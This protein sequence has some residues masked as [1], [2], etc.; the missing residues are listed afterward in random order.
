M[1]VMKRLVVVAAVIAAVA[2]G[3]VPGGPS[4]RRG[5]GV[6]VD[7]W[8]GEHS[9]LPG[10]RECASALSGGGGDHRLR[11]NR[12]RPRPRW[13]RRRWGS[14]ACGSRRASPSWCRS[15]SMADA[16]H[17]DA[18][19]G[20]DAHGDQSQGAGGDRG[21]LSRRPARNHPGRDRRGPGA[22]RAGREHRGRAAPGPAP[23]WWSRTTR[24]SD[25]ATA[26]S[27]ATSS[28]SSASISTTP[29]GSSRSRRSKPAGLGLLETSTGA[30]V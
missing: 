22:G 17:A 9:L 10:D 24:A 8:R 6:S 3:D 11:A 26:C 18:R 15:G 13:R 20:R 5:P 29:P 12:R 7:R 14:A 16:R 2:L 25:R 27:A 4:R 1:P 23:S 21:E 30:S 19:H 28:I